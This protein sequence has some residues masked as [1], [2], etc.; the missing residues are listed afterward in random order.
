MRNTENE[1]RSIASNL[2]VQFPLAE[3]TLQIVVDPSKSRRSI[4]ARADGRS[5]QKPTVDPSKSRRQEATVDPD[6]GWDGGRPGVRAHHVLRGTQRDAVRPPVLGRAD[7]GRCRPRR[8]VGRESDCPRDAPQIGRRAERL[9][10]AD[11]PAHGRR[12]VLAAADR[13]RQRDVLELAGHVRAGAVHEGPQRQRVLQMHLKIHRRAGE[14]VRVPQLHRRRHQGVHLL[15][16]LPGGGR[17]RHHPA[18][19]GCAAA[20]V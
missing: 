3:L 13:Q 6:N 20:G 5:Q 17:A 1:R 16:D 18:A 15:P 10:A 2:L 7:A 14:A 11:E 19:G 9:G 12:R 8:S 4:L